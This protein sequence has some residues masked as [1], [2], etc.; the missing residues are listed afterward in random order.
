VRVTLSMLTFVPGGMGGSETYAR[1]LARELAARDDVDLSV[2]VPGNAR[3][4]IRSGAQVV[5]E[6]VRTRPSTL[7]RLRAIASALFHAR[8]IRNSAAAD[9][10]HFPL[11]IPVPWPRRKTATVMTVHDVQH[12]DLPDLFSRAER[13]FRALAYERV[14]RRATLVVTVSE[15]ARNGIIRHLGVVPERVVVIP[16]G[17]DAAAFPVN[18]GAREDFAFYPARGWKHKNHPALVAAMEFVREQRPGMRLVL[19]GGGLDA[20]GALP[21]WVDVRGGVSQAEL[22]ELYRS[23]AVLAFPSR[24]EGFGLPPL[25]AMASGCPVAASRAG[26]LPEVC[27]SAAV[28]FDPDSPADIARGILEAIER[29]SELATAGLERVAEFTWARCAERHVEAYHEAIRLA[30]VSGRGAARR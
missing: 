8:G 27:G 10:V 11:T 30:G 17:V 28:F 26:S 7:G 1:E 2:V 18:R 21:D 22:Q 12:R 4:V 9:V 3:G 25:E 6:S 14:A 24:Y 29:R 13:L 23:A 15:F 19:T 20:L 16:H 5:V